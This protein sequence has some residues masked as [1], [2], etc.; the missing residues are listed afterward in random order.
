MKNY[1]T[2]F[3]AVSIV[4]SPAYASRARLESLGEGKNGSYYIDDARNMFLNPASIVRHKKKLF[5][6]LGGNTTSS[7]A[8]SAA[9]NTTTNSTTQNTAPLANTTTSATTYASRPQGGFT[10]TFGDFTYA[11][12]LNNVSDRG[13]NTLGVG[14]LGGFVAP[15]NSVEFALAGEGTVNWGVSALWGGNESGEARSYYWAARFGVE[16]DAAALF[17]TVGL[18]SKSV[19]GGTNDGEIKGKLSLDL[20]A[21]YKIDNMTLFAKYTQTGA[22]SN[23]DTSVTVPAGG[24]TASGANE[25]KLTTYGV[26]AG[27][28]KEMTKSTTMYSRLEFDY[29]R[30]TN[31]N[32]TYNLA[33]LAPNRTLWNVPVVL[34]AESQALSWL[35]IRGSIAH[36]LLGRNNTLQRSFAG[37]TTVSAGIGMTFGDIN[38]DGMVASNGLNSN[39]LDNTGFG[40]G[41]N[42]GSNFGFGDNMISRI[43]LTYNF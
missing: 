24:G 41:A 9:A 37:S 6:E 5:L 26:G 19:S 8:D 29:A 16:K 39:A 14:G 43:G 15:S 17:G 11:L 2:L 20:A 30:T 42:S 13:I 21:T 23:A 33:A 27:W 31:S 18:A 1:L 4:S 3:L 28:K 10:N 25:G 35:A 32:D 38:I 36:S 12:Y 22:E 7:S 34:A 40:T